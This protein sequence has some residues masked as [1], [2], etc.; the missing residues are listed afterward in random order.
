MKVYAEKMTSVIGMYADLD[1]IAIVVVQ[2]M[3]KYDYTHVVD[4][5]IVHNIRDIESCKNVFQ[6]FKEKYNIKYFLGNKLAHSIT[7]EKTHFANDGSVYDGWETLEIN[8]ENLIFSVQSNI[9]YLKFKEQLISHW[10]RELD[11]FDIYLIRNEKKSYP[12]TFALGIA[13]EVST[14][15]SW[16]TKEN[17]GGGIDDNYHLLY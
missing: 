10:K 16:Y 2:V 13:L 6:S 3:H 17:I 4:D 5:F 11:T 9:K 7:K 15:S 12:L 1:G 8:I 14:W